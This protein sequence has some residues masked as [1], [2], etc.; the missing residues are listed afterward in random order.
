MYDHLIWKEESRKIVYK[1]PV[2]EVGE[3]I[4]RSPKN[5]P[6]TFAVL[7]ARDFAIV[8][9]A[10]ETEKGR[11]F[12]MVRQ[13]RHGTGELSL[14]FPGGIIEKSEDNMQAALRELKE[15]TGYSAGRIIKLGEFGPNPA[16]MSN[17][18]HFFLAEDLINTGSQELDEDEYVK[19]ETI[20]W[21]EVFSGMGKAPYIHALMGTAMV[22]YLKHIGL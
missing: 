1:C 20:P 21:K 12:V 17:A 4:S 6:K 5:K 19:V 16:I 15:E 3:C 2:F 18:V 9:P 22:L 14:E 13:W 11:E 10:L 7:E 8:I